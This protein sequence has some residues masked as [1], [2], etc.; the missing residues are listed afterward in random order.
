MSPRV[1]GVVPARGGS[2]GIPR[3][4]LRSLAGKPLLEYVRDAADASG[5]IHRLVLTTDSE[6]IAELGRR[7]GLEVPFMRPPGLTGDDA[8]M[9]PTIEHA[10]RQV[11][12]AGWVP[13]IVVVLQPT[14]PLRRGDHLARAVEL[15][16]TTGASSV[17]SVVQ[18]PKHLSPHYVMKI[19]DGRLVNFLAEGAHVTRRQDALAAYTRDGTVYAVR[20]NVLLDEHDLYGTDCRPLVLEPSESLV[21]DTEQ[22]WAAAEA[23]LS[24]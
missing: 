12:E 23:R 8:P 15:L 22:D 21:L 10:A 16:T 2:K 7:V 11:E 5:V 9:Q 17:A 3:K 19:V 18:I 1:L 4:N 6:E 24:G 20:R 13:D 14:A